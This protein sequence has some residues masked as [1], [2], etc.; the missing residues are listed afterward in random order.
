MFP[1]RSGFS[2]DGQ[3]GKIIRGNNFCD[4]GGGTVTK[5]IYGIGSS[6][7]TLEGNTKVIIK[8]GKKLATWS[9]WWQ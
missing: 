3:M 4:D 1:D 5:N 6:G 9:L 2:V 8:G 7:G